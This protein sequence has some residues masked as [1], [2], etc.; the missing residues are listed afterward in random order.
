MVWYVNGKYVLSKSPPE[1]ELPP[2]TAVER[3]ILGAMAGVGFSLFLTAWVTIIRLLVGPEHF[4]HGRVSWLAVVVA[5]TAG[6]AIGGALIGVLQPLAGRRFGWILL[7]LVGGFA[8]Y[9]ACGIALF[10][11]PEGT[12]EY[13]QISSENMERPL[14]TSSA[15]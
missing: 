9:G 10:G 1:P 6:G 4:A 8:M 7:G 13:T 11:W 14:S 12:A 3:A 2:P 5:Y 15:G